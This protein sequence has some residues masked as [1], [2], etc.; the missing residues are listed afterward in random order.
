MCEAWE[1]IYDTLKE[2]GKELKYSIFK[3]LNKTCFINMINT[4]KLSE[5]LISEYNDKNLTKIYCI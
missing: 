5:L 4:K 1:D 3:E 2:H